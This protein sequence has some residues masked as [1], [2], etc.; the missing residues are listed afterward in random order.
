M[1][2]SRKALDLRRDP[3]LA[4]HSATVDPEMVAG[5]AKLAGRASEVTDPETI[6]RFTG[7]VVASGDPEP[8]TP[9]HL[10][11][12]D[13]MEVVLTRIGDPPDHLLIESWRPGEGYQRVDRY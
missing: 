9:F 4:L 3:R 13:I 11:R 12:V 2:D 5:D 1:P 10:F 6:A 7:A 8:P